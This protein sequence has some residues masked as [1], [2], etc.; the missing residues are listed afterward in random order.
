MI[1]RIPPPACR[2]S[3]SLIHPHCLPM[4]VGKAIDVVGNN[5]VDAIIVGTSLVFPSDVVLVELVKIL[6]DVLEVLTDVSILGGRL[7]VVPVD[8]LVV[9]DVVVLV[10]VEINGVFFLF[11]T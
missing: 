1:G 2:A 4:L 8:E 10:D 11:S 6:G 3:A 5:I 9:V 7:A